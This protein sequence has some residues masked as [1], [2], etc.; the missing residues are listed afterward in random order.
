MKVWLQLSR[1]PFTHRTLRSSKDWM[2]DQQ[3]V[4]ELGVQLQKLGRKAFLESGPKEFDRMLRAASIKL[5]C[6]S[7]KESWELENY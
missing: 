6:L 3:S 4:K 1:I 7:G 5:S 2:Q